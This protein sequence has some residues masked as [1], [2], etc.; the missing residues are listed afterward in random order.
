MKTIK[1][2]SDFERV[3]KQGRRY[4][5]PLMRMVICETVSE[6]DPGRVAFAA[7]KR[8]GNAVVRNRSKRVMREAARTCAFPIARRDVILFA[9][10]STRSATPR[11][12]RC[13]L[14]SLVHRAGVDV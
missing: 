8:L 4:N 11:E 13:A 9:T 7:P 12:L 2:R 10:A 1:A 6:G 3:Y 5:H 14:Q